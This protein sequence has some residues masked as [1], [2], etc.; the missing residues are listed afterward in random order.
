MLV[1]AV[2][3]ALVTMLAYWLLRLLTVAGRMTRTKR[4][5]RLEFCGISTMV[6]QE[7]GLGALAA[8]HARL[9]CISNYLSLPL[10]D[11]AIESK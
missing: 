6:D 2:F 5:Q 9:V 7:R 11:G 4:R 3:H 8:C 10:A 1:A